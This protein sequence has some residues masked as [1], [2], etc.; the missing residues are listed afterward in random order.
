MDSF[1]KDLSVTTKKKILNNIQMKIVMEMVFNTT[2][3]E[4]DFNTKTVT[5]AK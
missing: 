4:F 3:L 1:L 2:Q 5:L